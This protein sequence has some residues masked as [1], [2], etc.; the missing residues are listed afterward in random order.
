[1]HLTLRNNNVSKDDEDS[2]DEGRKMQSQVGL[3]ICH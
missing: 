2:L 1:M 3:P